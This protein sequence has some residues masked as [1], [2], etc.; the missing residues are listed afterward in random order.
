MDR[1]DAAVETRQSTRTLSVIGMEEA[2]RKGKELFT[3]WFLLA[4]FLFVFVTWANI[5]GTSSSIVCQKSLNDEETLDLPLLTLIFRAPLSEDDE[6]QVI[7]GVEAT[8]WPYYISHFLFAMTLYLMNIIVFQVFTVFFDVK[9]VFFSGF[10]CSVVWYI[11]REQRDYE[12]LGY[13]DYE[14]FYAPTL[15][16]VF[17]Y[18]FCQGCYLIYWKRKPQNSHHLVSKYALAAMFILFVAALIVSVMVNDRFREPFGP[19]PKSGCD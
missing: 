4:I 17:V 8:S 7:D 1:G 9:P 10:S 19:C 2:K 15:G 5:K 6:G 3:R 14:G 16:M 13:F 11:S 12:K 18:I